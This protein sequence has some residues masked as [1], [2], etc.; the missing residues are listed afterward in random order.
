MQTITEPPLP[1]T[2]RVS[3]PYVWPVREPRYEPNIA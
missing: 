3:R 2:E 1:K